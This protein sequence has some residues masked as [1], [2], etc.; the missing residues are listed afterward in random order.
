MI[1][2]NPT[3]RKRIADALRTAA[4]PAVIALGILVIVVL[5]RFPPAQYNF[6][7][8]CPIHE[9]THLQCPG[10]GATRAVAALLRGHLAEAMRLNALVTLLLPFVAAWGIV[11]YRR[12][13]QRK[14][15]RWA[16]PPPAVLYAAFTLAAVFTVIRNLPRHSF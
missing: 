16:Q 14:P 13:L 15:I 8:Q 9:L 11:C 3:S 6:Y 10:C 4:P 2:M 7:P 12:V 5:L 1:G